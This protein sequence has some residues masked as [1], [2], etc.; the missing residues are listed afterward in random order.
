MESYEIMR[1]LYGDQLYEWCVEL[2]NYLGNKGY[3]KN[4]TR[5]AE[6]AFSYLCFL[7]NLKG[8]I[9]WSTQTKQRNYKTLEVTQ[10]D[11][12]KRTSS[13]SIQIPN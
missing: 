11:N 1:D 7:C 12:I 2:V 13:E 5:L 9:V 3:Y 10:N 8:E 4:N 6:Q